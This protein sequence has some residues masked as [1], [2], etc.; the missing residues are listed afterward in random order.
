MNNRQTVR[1]I[2]CEINVIAPLNYLA[3]SDCH[4]SRFEF[5]CLPVFFALIFN[6]KWVGT[7]LISLHWFLTSD[8][9]SYSSNVLGSRLIAPLEKLIS[10]GLKFEHSSTDGS[11]EVVKGT[12]I[13]FDTSFQP[14][15]NLPWNCGFLC[16]RAKHLTGSFVVYSMM[17]W[18]PLTPNF[19]IQSHIFYM[20]R[21]PWAENKT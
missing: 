6:T 19:R 17:L 18:F 2:L 21:F 13:Y 11:S 16:L 9:D 3:V 1:S 4:S 7:A 5:F 20:W 10:A 8:Q 12:K 15:H 14:I